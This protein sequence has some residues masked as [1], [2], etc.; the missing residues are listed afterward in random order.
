M[1]RFILIQNISNLEFG[2]NSGGELCGEYRMQP[3]F[4]RLGSGHY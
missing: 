1:Q 3:N 2:L 4:S